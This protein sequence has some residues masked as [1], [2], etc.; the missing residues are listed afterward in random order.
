[1]KK[2][3]IHI[4]KMDCPSEENMIR[5]KLDKQ[6]FKKLEFDLLNR[7]LYVF[8]QEDINP[9]FKAIDDL[10]LDAKIESTIDYD[11]ELIQEDNSSQKRILWAV[12][13]INFLLFLIETITGLLSKSMGLVADSL[14]MLADAVVYSLSIYAVGKASSKKKN[15]ATVSGYLQITLAILG[16][17]EV[18]KRFIGKSE[19]PNF[20]TMIVI[21][22][23]ALAGNAYSL[24]L[25][26]K[27][28]SKDA[29]MQASMI[30]TS[31]DIIVN[32]GVIIAGVLV[33]F[34]GSSYPDLIVGIV[35]FIMV[36]NGAYRIL[37]LS[38]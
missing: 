17:I 37:K 38:K 26:Q 23:V 33:Y 7:K 4:S 10:N 12:L 11:F 20:Q 36:L 13:I 19:L 24:Y 28:K 27:S 25:L 30:F 3:T 9:I 8:H 16:I 2:T 34:T 1:M 6:H 29:H 15:I 22:I 14:D 32:I 21:S 5:L 31:N 35:V 18:V